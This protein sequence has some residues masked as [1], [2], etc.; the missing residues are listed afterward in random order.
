[1][2][3]E[4]ENILTRIKQKIGRNYKS[5]ASSHKQTRS[6][7]SKW[8]RTWTN[9]SIQICPD[10]DLRKQYTRVASLPPKPD[11][12]LPRSDGHRH[13][14]RLSL[15]LSVLT[16][17]QTPRHLPRFIRVKDPRGIEE[18]VTWSTSFE[19][20]TGYG[21]TFETRPAIQPVTGT[22][23]IKMKICHWCLLINLS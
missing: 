5:K 16:G 23:T 7:T 10:P 11:S 3:Q 2:T 4:I 13:T 12:R 17:H 6:R 15:S 1:M 18:E 8:N 20:K 14:H 19:R 9:K 22:Y 21:L